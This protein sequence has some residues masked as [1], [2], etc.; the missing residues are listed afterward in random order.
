MGSAQNRMY[1]WDLGAK[2]GKKGEAI[3]GNTDVWVG[4]MG[5]I[6]SSVDL[7]DFV[8]LPTSTADDLTT[9]KTLGVRIVQASRGIWEGLSSLLAVRDRI[10]S[11]WENK[12]EFK[13]LPMI[14]GKGERIGMVG[15]GPHSLWP[16]LLGSITP[17]RIMPWL[18]ER[19]GAFLPSPP[20]PAR[21]T[22]DPPSV[23]ASSREQST[24]GFSSRDSRGTS[25]AEDSGTGTGM[26]GSM[27]SEGLG[28]SWIGV[29][30]RG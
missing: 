30:E 21:I 14:R 28:E 4:E 18:V 25:T 1:G 17:Y 22:R 6:L 12:V 2:G 8:A 9:A 26:E 10:G 27:S 5:K 16:V 23:R 15:I 24:T 13:I 19:F 29:S 7:R 20:V 11:T 3:S